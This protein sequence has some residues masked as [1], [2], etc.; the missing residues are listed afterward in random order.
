MCPLL[1][2]VWCIKKRQ[3]KK[4]PPIEAFRQN[5]GHS[6]N[7]KHTSE[8]ENP[9]DVE[10]HFC[11]ESCSSQQVWSRFQLWSLTHPFDSN[12]NLE[13]F[14]HSDLIFRGFY[15]LLS[16]LWVLCKQGSEFRKR[17]KKERVVCLLSS[18][19]GWHFQ[20]KMYKKKP[21]KKQHC[22]QTYLLIL[23]C[24]TIN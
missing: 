22:R 5:G 23:P 1:W 13:I 4:P 17:K 7:C 14:F 15:K 2:E 9:K 20:C 12:T 10:G 18:E 11:W 24:G 3:S 16:S 8:E 19:A 6:E 21:P